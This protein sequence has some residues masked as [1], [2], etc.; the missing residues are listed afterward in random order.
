MK[1]IQPAWGRY[2]DTDTKTGRK[3]T[4]NADLYVSENVQSAKCQVRDLLSWEELGAA[5]EQL[6]YGLIASRRLAAESWQECAMV[7]RTSVITSAFAYFTDKEN[8][9]GG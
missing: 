8:Y 2:R 1:D 3:V 9:V 4:R 5:A 6:C 7:K